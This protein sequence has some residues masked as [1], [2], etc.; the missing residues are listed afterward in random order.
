VLFCFP[1]RAGVFFAAPRC[2][3][4]RGTRYGINAVLL[5]ALLSFG[6]G[7]GSSS[8][9]RNGTPAGS[10]TLTVTGTSGS[11]THAI[12]LTLNVD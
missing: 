8:S 9:S 3:G 4:R 5:F 2:V 7:G 6:C 12:A 10:Y 11:L 1:L